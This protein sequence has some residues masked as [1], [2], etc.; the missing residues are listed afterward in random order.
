[1]KKNVKKRRVSGRINVSTVAGAWVFY[2]LAAVM[3][4]LFLLVTAFGVFGVDLQGDIINSLPKEFK[5]AVAA[6]FAAAENATKGVTLFFIITVFISGSQF[7]SQMKKDGEYIYGVSSDKGGLIKRIWAVA[8][9][10]VMFAVF[11]AIALFFSFERYLSRKI[12]GESGTVL[13][14]VA[15]FTAVITVCFFLN[16]MLNAFASPVKVAFSHAALGS[17]VSLGVIVLGTIAFIIYLRL[18]DPYDPF[19]GSLTTAIVA[20]F[21]TYII[22]LG[23][24]L[25]VVTTK[26]A[27]FRATDGKRVRRR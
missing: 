9:I 27:Y 6:A 24:V 8:A 4:I 16:A 21:W 20:L 19:Y 15:A 23:L 18:F 10:G 14:T 12:F 11:L 3:P 7:L 1:M 26:S 13:I 17:V 2:F 5:G 22:M 25:G